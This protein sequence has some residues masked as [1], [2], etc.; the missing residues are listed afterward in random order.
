MEIFNW[1]L[2]E[3][4][5][6][7]RSVCCLC[8]HDIFISNKFWT[9]I[10]SRSVCCLVFACWLGVQRLQNPKLTLFDFVAILAQALAWLKYCVVMIPNDYKCMACLVTDATELEH[11]SLLAT[12]AKYE[13]IRWSWRGNLRYWFLCLECHRRWWPSDFR[14]Q[15]RWS[16]PG[17][18]RQQRLMA[19]GKTCLVSGDPLTLGPA[20][21]IGG[22]PSLGRRERRHVFPCKKRDVFCCKR[23][24]GFSCRR[25]QVFSCKRWRVFSCRR[26]PFF[27]CNRRHVFSR[28]ETQGPSAVAGVLFPSMFEHVWKV[29]VFLKDVERCC[30][31]C[32]PLSNGTLKDVK[33]K[34]ELII[35]N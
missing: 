1:E 21:R 9:H 12:W 10:T 2:S 16:C 35:I 19:N 14:V 18:L 3:T 31:R 11:P 27:S 32:A 23:R 7:T 5:I 4:R 26:R 30:G 6:T 22:Y 13:N 33:A 29:C 17:W 20:P 34:K 24:T 28:T 15:N 25:R 8:L